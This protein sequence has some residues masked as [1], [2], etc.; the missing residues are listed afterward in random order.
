MRVL[1]PPDPMA[2]SDSKAATPKPVHIGGESIAD[3]LI[4]HVK[5]ILV[6]C[7][8]VAVVITGVFAFKWWRQRGAE[9][10]TEKLHAVL[11]V[12]D[13]PI[14]PPPPTDG[15]AAPPPPASKE[16]SF[17]STQERA[18]AV[19]AELAAQGTDLAGPVYRAGLLLDAGKIDDAIADYRKQ[20]GRPGL[21]GVMAREGLG[22][23]LET[24]AAAEQ[25]AGARQK[26]L[27]EA[28]AAFASMQPDEQGV[29][30]VYALYHQGR[31]NEALGKK[32]EAKA[33][34]EKAQPLANG[35][36]IAEMI[37]HRL[38]GLGAT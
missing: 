12:A 4:P 26:L 5:K 23:A 2:D 7:V 32:A 24:K 3:R 29:R 25:D 10:E 20:I 6:A 9:Q 18:T 38:A 33:L 15:S 21:D 16:P 28:L 8:L 1:H 19:L 14:V 35:L 17:A 27:E 11:A 30:Y 31:L 13:R 34:F 36:D 37:E 22:V